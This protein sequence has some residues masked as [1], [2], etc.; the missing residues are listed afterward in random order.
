MLKPHKMKDKDYIADVMT[1]CRDVAAKYPKFMD[2]LEHYCGYN[3]PVCSSD[4]YQ[5]SYS[6]GKRD[7]ILMLKTLQRSDILPEQIAEYYERNI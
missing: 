1:A 4:P 5:I 3:T 2:F 6:G 7:V